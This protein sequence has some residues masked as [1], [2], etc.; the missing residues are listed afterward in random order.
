MGSV[1]KWGESHNKEKKNRQCQ[2]INQMK[3]IFY[4]HQVRQSSVAQQKIGKKQIIY[5][6]VYSM[7]YGHHVKLNI[8]IKVIKHLTTG[9]EQNNNNS[10]KAHYTS[11]TYHQHHEDDAEAASLPSTS[12]NGGGG[13][14]GLPG[15][16]PLPARA[17]SSNHRPAHGPPAPGSKNCQANCQAPTPPAGRS[18]PVLPRRTK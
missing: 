14:R 12:G 4:L 6:H 8:T 2:L 1:K 18:A 13:A 9:E 7:C 17:A 10:K 15:A 16:H 5:H 3:T 11:I